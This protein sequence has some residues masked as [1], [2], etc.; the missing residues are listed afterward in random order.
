MMNDREAREKSIYEDMDQIHYKNHQGG[1]WPEREREKTSYVPSY[2]RAC[3]RMN[4]V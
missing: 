1:K 3:I 4:V 2:T